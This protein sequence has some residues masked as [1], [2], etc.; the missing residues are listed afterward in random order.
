MNRTPEQISGLKLEKMR[1]KNSITMQKLDKIL[2]QACDLKQ[3]RDY[4]QEKERGKER[5]HSMIL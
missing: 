3:C 4:R 1:Y 5:S 2:L